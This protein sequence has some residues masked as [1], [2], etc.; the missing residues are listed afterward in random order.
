MAGLNCYVVGLIFDRAKDIASFIIM[1]MAL[2][3]EVLSILHSVV[4]C[5]QKVLIELVRILAYWGL[6]VTG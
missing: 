6:N 5:I 1:L 3:Q 4:H 2:Q